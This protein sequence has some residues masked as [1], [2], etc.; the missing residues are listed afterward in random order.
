MFP[1]R[2]PST[3]RVT[4]RSTWCNI[5]AASWGG[6]ATVRCSSTRGSLE[7]PKSEARSGG[8]S[9]SASVAPPKSGAEPGGVGARHVGRPGDPCIYRT[10]I[11]GLRDHMPVS[12]F[13]RLKSGISIEVLLAPRKHHGYVENP[14]PCFAL[15]ISWSSET[16]WDSEVPI[17]V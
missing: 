15:W 6:N 9:L 11:P 17:H 3:Y 7:A 13:G 12:R 2:T 4:R 5:C 8:S 14:P 16:S 1:P 10:S